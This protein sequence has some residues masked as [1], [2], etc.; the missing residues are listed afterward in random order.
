MSGVRVSGPVRFKRRSILLGVVAARLGPGGLLASA[1]VG[2][3]LSIASPA[4]AAVGA[5]SRVV[6]LFER[7]GAV[8]DWIDW[9]VGALPKAREGIPPD[10]PPIDTRVAGPM[11]QIISSM[12]TVVRTLPAPQLTPLSSLGA[13]PREGDTLRNV[14]NGRLASLAEAI[15]E[16]RVQSEGLRDLHRLHAEA[17]RRRRGIARLGNLL[18]DILA[19]MPLTVLTERLGP[20]VLTLVPPTGSVFAAAQTL[21]DVLAER[22]NAS[23]EILEKR[24]LELISALNE[25]SFALSLEAASVK[26]DAQALEARKEA[27]AGRRRDLDASR[28]D[29]ARLRADILALGSQIAGFEETVRQRKWEL[30]RLSDRIRSAQSRIDDLTPK[31]SAGISGFR[32]C[33][34]GAIYAQCSHYALKAEFDDQLARWKQGLSDAKSSR[35]ASISRRSSATQEQSEAAEQASRLRERAQRLGTEA[36]TQEGQ[37]EA[38]ERSINEESSKLFADIYRLR[39]TEHARGNA[40]NAQRVRQ[41]MEKLDVPLQTL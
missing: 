4:D 9:Y 18:V 39:A 26:G 10:P 22:F 37:V 6:E 3:A 29:V 11:S 34:N 36:E 2:G 12:T 24:R 25:L 17:E 33:P 1:S 7:L 23:R 13:L 19:G 30:E 16:Q 8:R 35:A 40:A 32:L 21:Q 41:Y 14:L 38:N 31:V 15:D 28:G 27:L 5:A 20:E